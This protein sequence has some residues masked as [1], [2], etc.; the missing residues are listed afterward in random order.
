MFVS[1]FAL[2]TNNKL[3]KINAIITAIHGPT[4]SDDDARFSAIQIATRSFATNFT[5]NPVVLTSREVPKSIQAV[6]TI[7]LYGEV[8]DSDET[9][10]F[11]NFLEPILDQMKAAGIFEVFQPVFL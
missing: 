11:F 3:A 1:L 4:V 9:N 10:P 6:T 2:C 7:I 8:L 5:T